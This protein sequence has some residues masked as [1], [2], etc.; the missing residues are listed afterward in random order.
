MAAVEIIAVVGAGLL[1]LYLLWRLAKGPSA[2]VPY[3]SKLPPVQGGLPWIGCAM[4]FGKEPLW[5]IGK[6]YSKV[7]LLCALNLQHYS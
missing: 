6:S 7:M 3:G 5:Y 4:Q 1:F 2:H